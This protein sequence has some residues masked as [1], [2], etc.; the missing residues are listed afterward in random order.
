MDGEQE[1]DWYLQAQAGGYVFLELSE[2][3]AKHNPP[4]GWTGRGAKVRGKYADAGTALTM[5][6][7]G[8]DRK[9]LAVGS[10]SGTR[11]IIL[12]A[13]DEAAVA[14]VTAMLDQAGTVTLSEATPR[15]V[16]WFFTLPAG[17]ELPKLNESMVSGLGLLG[18]RVAG[19]Y[20]LGPGSAVDAKC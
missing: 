10:E 6:G 14:A 9:N 5:R 18:T 7:D 1:R 4:S 12:D 15:G 2:P 11:C 13:D 16:A 20:Q 3:M 19:Q 17:V 8:A